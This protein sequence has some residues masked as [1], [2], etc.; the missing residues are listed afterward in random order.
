MTPIGIRDHLFVRYSSVSAQ[1]LHSSVYPSSTRCSCHVD[2][3]NATLVTI[4]DP[5]NLARIDHIRVVDVVVPG[6]RLIRGAIAGSDTTK[7]VSM[8]N[9]DGV[10]VA[11]RPGAGAR[12]GVA[13]MLRR[14]AGSAAGSRAMARVAAGAAA[15][16]AA[17]LLFM[18][19]LLESLLLVSPPLL[20]VSPLYVH[21]LLVSLLFP[22]GDAV[23]QL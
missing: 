21:L 16:A 1:S 22:V 4:G 13:A 14:A 7:R 12:A 10:A 5:Q 9:S 6:N 19:A 20:L 3:P 11:A 17:A 8:L 2:A 23:L 18:A 15:G